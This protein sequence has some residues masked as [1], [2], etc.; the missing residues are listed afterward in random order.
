MDRPLGAATRRGTTS[1][2]APDRVAP[3]QSARA[4]TPDRLGVR[5]RV[6]RGSTRPESPSKSSPPHN[7]RRRPD[8][9]QR[10]ADRVR[11]ARPLVLP[12]PAPVPRYAAASLRTRASAC[13][14]LK[15]P[16]LFPHALNPPPPDAARAAHRRPSS[17]CEPS[18]PALARLHLH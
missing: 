10:T 8:G 5:A 2:A 13:V 3:R 1:C 16:L 15:G 7:A 11:T 9:I 18:Q 17:G 6:A 4:R 12:R 14:A